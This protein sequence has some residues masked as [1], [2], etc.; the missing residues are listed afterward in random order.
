MKPLA[1]SA[2]PSTTTLT[3]P[4]VDRKLSQH[5]AVHGAEQ[6]RVRARPE[7]KGYK[8]DGGPAF[9]LQQHARGKPK[10]R[11]PEGCNVGSHRGVVNTSLEY[12]GSRQRR[13]VAEGQLDGVESEIVYGC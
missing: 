9:G 5:Q 4:A 3:D 2:S 13:R 7:S 8:D 11:Q 12:N 6:R 10:I 1:I